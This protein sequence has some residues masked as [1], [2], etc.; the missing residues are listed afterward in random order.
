MRALRAD[1]VS[2]RLKPGSALPGQL[3]LARRFG[4]SPMTVMLAI[5]QLASEGR[6]RIQERVGTFVVDRQPHLSDY[7]LVFPVDPVS[8]VEVERRL[9]SKYYHAFTVAAA[10][11]QR[12]LGP[13]LAIFHGIGH[14]ADV[15][16]RQRL[17]DL[18][19]AH[20]LAGLIFINSPHEL[21][22]TPIMDEPGIP[23]VALSNVQK[24]P[25]VLALGF[26]GE[27][28]FEQAVDLLY[29]R[30]RR[31]VAVLSFRLR[32]AIRE[33]VDRAFAERGLA[34]PPCWQ[35]AVEWQDPEAVSH[36]VQLLMRGSPSERPDGLLITD[37]N[38]IEGVTAGLVA[39]GIRVPA[40]L[41][42]VA[43]AN[44]PLGTPPALPF[45]LLG[46]D[47]GGALRRAM[48]LIDRQRQGETVAG[49]TTLPPLWRQDWVPSSPR[50]EAVTREFVE[51]NFAGAE[52]PR[53]T[54]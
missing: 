17:V 4:V 7:A 22:N 53:S 18:I 13:R 5:R 54:S 28:W 15:E 1:I 47:L 2:G 20:R 32:A 23:R 43:Q 31:R 38:L 49:L 14:H 39:A 19:H 44:Y 52:L 33:W 42:V 9:W 25:H 40:D 41:E 46:N 3:A 37:D 36:C 29:R 35:Q 24:W 16:D 48:D 12:E 34:C 11:L 51:P 26:D 30:G 27:R 50:R 6:L 10:E 8:P 21:V 45:H